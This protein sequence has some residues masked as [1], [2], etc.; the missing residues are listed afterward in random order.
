MEYF[1]LSFSFLFFFLLLLLSF[2]LYL[3]IMS[4]RSCFIDELQCVQTRRGDQKTPSGVLFVIY[5]RA[6]S[7]E[8]KRKRKTQAPK[9][10]KAQTGRRR[11]PFVR[12]VHHFLSKRRS[13]RVSSTTPS[14]TTTTTLMRTL[15]LLFCPPFNG[16]QSIERWVIHV[17][18]QEEE[19]EDNNKK[20]ATC[21]W[22]ANQ[23]QETSWESLPTL[24]PHIFKTA[25][26][27]K[28][29]FF[30]FFFLCTLSTPL[31]FWFCFV[32]MYA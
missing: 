14:T 18:H 5:S 32:T 8:R 10:P 3:I 27:K 23:T 4:F 26:K 19:E 6:H 16:S 25:Q 11:V 7:V 17:Q 1:F 28:K 22:P 2:G 30:F 20:N 15:F 13:L 29:K 31:I 12:L 21:T 24:V 9:L